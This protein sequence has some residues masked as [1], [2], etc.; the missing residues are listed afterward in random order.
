MFLVFLELVEYYV[1]REV[2]KEYFELMNVFWRIF[3]L[4]INEDIEV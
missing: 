2:C 3:E 4:G 1:L